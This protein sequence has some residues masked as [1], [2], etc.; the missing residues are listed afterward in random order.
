V[1]ANASTVALAF[2]VPDLRIYFC[3]AWGYNT[4]KSRHTTIPVFEQLKIIH[5]L[6][7][8][9]WPLGPIENSKITY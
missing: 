3:L 6:D 9:V 7:H 8:V 1:A 5:A 2:F 4:E